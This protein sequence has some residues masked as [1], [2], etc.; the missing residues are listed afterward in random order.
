MDS[1]GFFF[2]F[3]ILNNSVL[4]KSLHKPLLLCCVVSLETILGNGI[5]DVEGIDSFNAPTCVS[6]EF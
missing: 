6:K 5:T 4:N 2:F 3:P 1:R